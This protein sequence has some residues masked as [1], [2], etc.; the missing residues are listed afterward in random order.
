MI[1]TSRYCSHSSDSSFSPRERGEPGVR[2][3]RDLVFSAFFLIVL[4][5][6]GPASAD[7][8]EF[9]SSFGPNYLKE[10]F[11][12]SRHFIRKDPLDRNPYFRIRAE[13]GD[14]NYQPREERTDFRW[15]LGYGMNRLSA[16]ETELTPPA[17]DWTHSFRGGFGWE[18]TSDI[19]LAVEL[20][21]D[22]GA[23]QKYIMGGARFSLTYLWA[24]TE[25]KARKGVTDEELELPFHLRHVSGFL[26]RYDLDA[27]GA[28]AADPDGPVLALRFHFAELK[29]VK[30]PSRLARVKS[31]GVAVPVEVPE[32]LD[33]FQ[34]AFTLAP[35]LTWNRTSSLSLTLDYYRYSGDESEFLGAL[36]NLHAGVPG[37]D[38]Y[39]ATLYGLPRYRVALGFNHLLSRL[40]SFGLSGGYTVYEPDAAAKAIDG[41]LRIGRFVGR[42]WQVSLR[43]E[44]RQ[45]S[46]ASV[47]GG[48]LGVTR[49]LW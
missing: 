24:L 48:E 7:S 20:H 35:E 3:R 2:S 10:F 8:W 46:G 15:N 28:K 9:K 41:A 22:S 12:I 18:A 43:G 36:A 1:R 6:P 23:S 30:D 33:L 40:W 11:S 17:A 14:E 42:D 37:R 25:P 44:Y 34:Q 4:L 49:F 5:L 13:Q 38:G 19:D 26:H 21:I 16:A 32:E 27:G 47:I 29:H 31:G 45:A 39:A